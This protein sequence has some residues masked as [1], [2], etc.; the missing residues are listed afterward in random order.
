MQALHEVSVLNQASFKFHTVSERLSRGL[1]STD[2]VPTCFKKSSAISFHAEYND[3][4]GYNFDFYFKGND[5]VELCLRVISFDSTFRNAWE[6]RLNVVQ[7]NYV[8]KKT[9]T[10]LSAIGLETLHT[11]SENVI[12]LVRSVVDMLNMASFY[13]SLHAIHTD[14]TIANKR[15]LF[16]QCSENSKHDQPFNSFLINNC[17]WIKLDKTVK[18]ANKLSGLKK[19][20]AVYLI[21]SQFYK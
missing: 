9:T 12:F 15:C 5:K 11:Q 14:V 7:V 17:Q 18:E 3:I 8:G 16:F 10:V 1:Y 19:G 4:T 20:Y 6:I 13:S 21:P 2:K